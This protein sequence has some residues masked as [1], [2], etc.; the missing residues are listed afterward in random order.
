MI[1]VADI[2]GTKTRVARG[3][4]GG[5]HSA[6]VVYATPR[7]YREGI[8]R[9]TKELRSAAGA[10]RI[11]MVVIAIAGVLAKDH[12]RV[13]RSPHLPDWNGMDLESDL[14]HALNANVRIEND[15]AL[16]ALGE[17]LHGAGRGADIVAYLSIGTGVGGARI[18]KGAIDRSASGF[19]PG[20]QYVSMNPP[21][22]LEELVSGTALRMR[23]HR[24][25][26]ELF[27]K[28]VWE[29]CAQ[30]LAY[31]IHNAILFWSPD[32]VVLGGTMMTGNP[33]I[34]TERVAEH[35]RELMR[36]FPFVPDI[37]LAAFGDS[38]GLVGAL[39]YAKRH[40]R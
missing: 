36:I 26:E 9:L 8:A 31:G 30:T 12:A 34:R 7:S 6:P 20:H 32:V 19:E 16:A 18:V 33:R 29:E 39:A 38:A 24:P 37:R 40:E 4:A 10:E 27:D 25:A 5:A 1:L 14:A 35:V 21:R 11:S 28:E 17:A 23:F 15:A 2:G 22:T 3:E 13:L